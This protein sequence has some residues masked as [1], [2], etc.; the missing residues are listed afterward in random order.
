MLRLTSTQIELNNR[1]LLWHKDRSLKRRHY[2]RTKSMLL[3]RPGVKIPK[4]DK[5]ALKQWITTPGSESDTPPATS[6]SS[7][8]KDM[9]YLGAGP[10]QEDA[11]AVFDRL[12]AD[13]MNAKKLAATELEHLM[14]PVG[15]S[16]SDAGESFDR[17]L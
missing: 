10:T 11:D 15:E 9:P 14:H 12:N 3:K 4:T 8:P 1:D 2:F 5:Q 16:T 13:A 17:Q 7:P 6:E